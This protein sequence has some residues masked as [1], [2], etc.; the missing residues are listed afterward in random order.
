MHLFRTFRGRLSVAAI[1][2]VPLLYSA[3]Y[4]GAFWNPYGHLDRIPV[5][6]VNEDRGSV[7][8]DLIQQLSRR[9]AVRVEHASQAETDLANGQVGMIMEIPPRFSRN[10]DRARPV[11]LDFRTNPGTNYLTSILMEREATKVA[12]NLAGSVRQRIL[13]KVSGGLGQLSQGAQKVA[14]GTG[15]ATQGVQALA[16]QNN[17]LQGASTRLTEGENR[18]GEGLAA[19]NTGVSRLGKVM[20]ELQQGDQKTLAAAHA[21]SGAALGIGQG[22]KQLASSTEAVTQHLAALL[23]GTEEL[24]HQVARLGEVSTSLASAA[25]QDSAITRQIQK[26]LSSPETPG[27]LSEVQSLIQQQEQIQTALVHGTGEMGQG[28]NALSTSSGTLSHGMSTLSSGLQQ[29]TQANLTLAQKTASW[30]GKV[31]R[32]Q[33]GAGQVSQGLN[34]LATALTNLGQ[35]SYAIS[36]GQKALTTGLTELSRGQAA[37]ASAE[38]TLAQKMAPLKDGSRHV[39][40]ILPELREPLRNVG[41]PVAV[42]L[43]SPGQAS[44][45]TGMA[46]YFLGLSLWV[47]AVVATVLVPGGRYQR[48][49]LKSRTTQSFLVAGL[50]VVLLGVGTALV[51]PLH[52]VHPGEYALALIGIGT[53]W[54]AV[55]RLLVEKFGDAG[56]IV[57]IVLLV[58]QLAGSGGTYPVVLS[59]GF[60][61]TIHPYLPMTWAIH[62]LRWTLSNGYPRRVLSDAVRL[63]ILGMGALALVRWLPAQWLF[64]APVLRES[65]GGDSRDEIA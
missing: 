22:Q 54:W 18:L 17:R 13:A 15:Q 57:G 31:R 36:S 41:T 16:V 1:A 55:I 43:T 56:R 25:A 48:R 5:A 52:P 7:S 40:A 4:L 50:Q 38:H 9:L 46:P 6:V 24:H 39:A 59:P 35:K 60:F 61:Q 58:V 30:A 26:L 11:R 64:E 47:G 8:G 51:L 29:V 45:G 63:A 19:W 21:L 49:A 20:G 33:A 34:S 10:L 3:A 28:T 65:N 37:V 27:T 14:T 23:G 42:R 62:V 12:N 53:V 44:Y 2:A 32:W